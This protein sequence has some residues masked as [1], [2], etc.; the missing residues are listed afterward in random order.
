MEECT[1]F[2]CSLCDYSTSRKTNYLR[3][4]TTKRHMDNHSVVA[5]GCDSNVCECGKS[6]V[7]ASGLSRHRAVCPVHLMIQLDKEYD[8]EPRD[9]PTTDSL[10]SVAD[11]QTDK[12]TQ[13]ANADGDIKTIL[14]DIAQQLREMK[15]TQALQQQQI[16]NN[17]NINNNYILNLN[18]YLNENCKDALSLQDFVKQ[19]TFVFDDLKDK[20]WRSKVLL[21]NLGSLK[22]ENRPFHCVD[23]NT[24]QVV[25]K[26]GGQWQE[27]NKDDIVSTLD[28]CGKHVQKQFGP[29]WD[30]Q[31][32]DW[33]SSEQHSRRYMDLW[34]NITQDPS[35]SQ[36]EE[37]LK[38]VSSKTVL[39]RAESHNVGGKHRR[40]LPPVIKSRK[41][42]ATPE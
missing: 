34:W 3:H 13:Q 11:K 12:L 15:E 37:D 4:V 38:N 7:H 25:M 35:Q 29:Q 31:Y 41:P 5:S 8:D 23:T 9:T 10:V 21:N 40:R 26:N 1:T 24:C 20:S 16:T 36:V 2:A 14:T 39:D 28:S 42:V 22:V 6:Y 17:N 33:T 18:M 19:I 27:G 32:P 30:S